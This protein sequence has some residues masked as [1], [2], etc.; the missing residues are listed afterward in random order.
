MNLHLVVLWPFSS[1]RGVSVTDADRIEQILN[2]EHAN[3]VVKVRS[4]EPEKES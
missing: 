3:K 1:L 2:S 4:R